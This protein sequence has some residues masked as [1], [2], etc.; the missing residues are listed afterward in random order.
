[1]GQPAAIATVLRWPD[2]LVR[3][4]P[5]KLPMAGGWL[6]PLDGIVVVVASNGRIQEHEHEW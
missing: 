1:M 4:N 3:K 2:L 5:G 6:F